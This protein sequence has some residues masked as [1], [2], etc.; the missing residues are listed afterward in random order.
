[1]VLHGRP[2]LSLAPDFLLDLADFVL[3]VCTLQLFVG[4]TPE[5][6]RV[7]GVCILPLDQYNDRC[8]K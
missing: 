8:E 4:T 6:F 7:S 2:A 5:P 3:A 1:M